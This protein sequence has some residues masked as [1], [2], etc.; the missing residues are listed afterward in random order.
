MVKLLWM[1]SFPERLFM[2]SD[3]WTPLYQLRRGA[4]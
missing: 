1:E 2:L 4:P 3:P